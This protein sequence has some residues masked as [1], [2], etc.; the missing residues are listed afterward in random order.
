MGCFR[1]TGNNSD[2]RRTAPW[3]RN[4]PSPTLLKLAINIQMQE[5]SVTYTLVE[6]SVDL[7][8]GLARL[9][10]DD[11][12]LEKP[13][14]SDQ[15]I[16]SGESSGFP[17]I[18][19]VPIKGDVVFHERLKVRAEMFHV[20]DGVGAILEMISRISWYFRYGMMKY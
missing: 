7:P 17:E 12:D 18:G 1:P 6:T 20:L 5:L 11:G 2:I 4:Y 8:D 19:R 14:E 9:M 3:G 10:N 16:V 15:S 13:R